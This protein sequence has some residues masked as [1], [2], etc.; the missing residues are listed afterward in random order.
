MADAMVE[1][2][3]RETGLFGNVVPELAED[4]VKDIQR[5]V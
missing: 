5:A 3:P 2:I 4:I 1:I